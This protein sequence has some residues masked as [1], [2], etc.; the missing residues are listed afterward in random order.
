[1]SPTQVKPPERD[2]FTD[3]MREVRKL[4]TRE[5]AVVRTAPRVA[6]PATQKPRTKPKRKPRKEGSG[7]T[8][9]IVVALGL[10]LIL[11]A[12]LFVVHIIL[13]EFQGQSVAS[14][15]QESQ[16]EMDILRT[17]LDN[18]RQA[19]R[20]GDLANALTGY[21]NVSARANRLLANL[22]NRAATLS[23]GEESE[24]V[25]A[26]ISELREIASA[27]EEA[28]AIPEITYG[29]QGKVEYQGEWMFPE[30]QQKRFEAHMKAEGKQLYE[31]EYLTRAE[32]AERRGE[33]F[34]NGQ[35]I[36]KAE[37]EEIMTARR[38][39]ENRADDQPGEEPEPPTRPR[40]TPR[41]AEAKDYSPDALRWVISDFEDGHSWRAVPRPAWKVNPCR[42]STIEGTESKR[43]ALTLLPGDYDKSAIIRPLRMDLSSRFRLKLAVDNQ[44][45]QHVPVAI[46]IHTDEYYESRPVM[47]PPGTS[48]G[49]TFDLRAGDFKHEP[50]WSFDS[51]VSH[52]EQ[53]GYL[54]ILVYH[55]VYDGSDNN[56]LL[57]DNI[58][59]QGGN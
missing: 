44:C 32:I 13:S 33:V 55:K 11:G 24:Q 56:R 20:E 57:L 59:L 35:Y 40:P 27:A 51:R 7:R 23:P 52:L 17:G 15:I 58:V 53:G 12:S 34:Y 22:T 28:L 6:A 47:V 25:Q 8:V 5:K 1:M 42:L 10:V 50:K 31:G 9:P 38:A 18:A 49:I 37:Y 30:E 39:M 43:L 4:E 26:L 29:G 48:S 19:H 41:D 3:L 45:G 54:H 2:L 21:R 46:A 16:I 36:P 14:L